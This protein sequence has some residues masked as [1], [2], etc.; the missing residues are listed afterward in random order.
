LPKTE[1]YLYVGAVNAG[2]S[3]Q[4]ITFITTK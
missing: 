4:E 3:S 1:Y 2:G